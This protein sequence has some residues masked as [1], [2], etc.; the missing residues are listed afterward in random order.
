M[1][2]THLDEE[3]TSAGSSSTDSSPEGHVAPAPGVIVVWTGGQPAMEIVEMVPG[4]LAVRRGAI[5]SLAVDDARISQ[6]HAVLQRDGRRWSLRD[7]RSRNGTFVDGARIHGEL[8]FD[9][10]TV[11]RVGDTL[12]VPSLDVRPLLGGR[13]ESH[14]GVC[15]GPT[16]AAAR[17]RLTAAGGAGALLVGEPGSGKKTLARMAHERRHRGAAPFVVA[18]ADE[19]ADAARL[20]ARVASARGGTL[21]ADVGPGGSVPAR[22]LVAAVSGR[23]GAAPVWL[24]LARATLSRAAQSDA[25]ERSLGDPVELPPL[26]RRPEELAF[27]VRAA[28]ASLAPPLPPHVSLIERALGRV[29][30][31]NVAELAREVTDAHVRA[32]SAE[33]DAVR[34]RHLADGAGMLRPD[35]PLP[36]RADDL[37]ELTR[38]ERDVLLCV[39][40]GMSEKE[41]A[42]ALELSGHTVHQHIKSIHKKL[43]VRSRGELLARFVAQ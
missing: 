17:D 9:R 15:V 25:A 33:A 1:S 13:V 23:A 22:D 34:G 30:L 21:Y 2:K 28:L 42:G 19:L 20:A 43:R 37:A 24:V 40:R 32:R 12:L 16:L 5:G 26:R 3:A 14:G 35:A 29:W 4:G 41:A 36:A 31:G 39:L 7:V 18:Q 10:A 11:I 8:R 38:R 27:L 6:S